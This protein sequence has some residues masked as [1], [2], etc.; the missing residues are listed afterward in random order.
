VPDSESIE[1]WQQ[2]R[3]VPPQLLKP[4]PTVIRVQE[5][6]AIARRLVAARAP[7][8]SGSESL[9]HPSHCGTH[10]RGLKG[11]PRM[12]SHCSGAARGPATAPPVR[13][14][15]ASD[16]SRGAVWFRW[17]SAV[18]VCAVE[19]M[20]IDRSPRARMEGDSGL[21]RVRPN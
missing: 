11:S 13:E 14:R 15:L 7:S 8:D 10:Q 9:W 21:A 12:A 19:M 20:S 1:A 4:P 2:Q 6:P 18:G 17:A 16:E 5:P 3:A